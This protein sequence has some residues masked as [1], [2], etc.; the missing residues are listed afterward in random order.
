L[1]IRHPKLRA[2]HDETLCGLESQ[3]NMQHPIP[4]DEDPDLQFA[5]R[6]YEGCFARL[7][8][9][10]ELTRI[11][12]RYVMELENRGSTIARQRSPACE[13]ET[14]FVPLPATQAARK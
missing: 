5:R 8:E 12:A 6:L 7:G 11:V 2:P 14:T 1:N 4:A 3:Y 13:L 10:H 9:H